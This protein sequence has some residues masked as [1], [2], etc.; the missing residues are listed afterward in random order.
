MGPKIRQLI[1]APLDGPTNMGRDAALL[2][3]VDRGTSP[4][5]LR[6]YQWSPATISLGYFQ[7][8]DDYLALTSPAGALPVVRRVTG[9]GAILHDAELTYSL[10]LPFTHTLAA[11]DPACLYRTMHAAIIAGL[12]T[13]G[14]RA[15]PRGRCGSS[16]TRR[17]GPFFCFSRAHPTDVVL[18]GA[19]L[20]GSAQRRTRRAVL[21]H[22]SIMLGRRY[23]QQRCAIVGSSVDANAVIAAVV[24]DLTG[25]MDLAIETGAWTEV[26]LR[27]AATQRTR[28]AD[29]TF[30]RRR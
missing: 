1:D 6:W 2:A 15:D 20:V 19:K 21:Q 10:A 11:G 9:G 4:P 24:S 12:R 7:R 22:G 25:Y 3:G 26:E 27:D 5:T 17:E 8:Y 14:V 13:L 29:P 18:E 16:R 23:A 28:F 30:T